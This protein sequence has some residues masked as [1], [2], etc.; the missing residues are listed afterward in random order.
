ML[1]RLSCLLVVAQLDVSQAFCMIDA[2]GAVIHEALLPQWAPATSCLAASLQPVLAGCTQS[3][4]ACAAKMSR[5]RTVLVLSSDEPTW[6][7]DLPASVGRYWLSNARNFSAVRAACAGKQNTVLVMEFG[8]GSAE[9]AV[10]ELAMAVCNPRVVILRQ[11]KLH[12][13]QAIMGKQRVPMV[14]NTC[15]LLFAASTLISAMAASQISGS[16]TSTK[17]A[18]EQI[19][20]AACKR[21][22]SL[23]LAHKLFSQLTLGHADSNTSVIFVFSHQPEPTA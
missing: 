20:E 17:A 1:W 2:D 14:T 5:A 15:R 13:L 11:L 8:V 12:K 7:H 9:L 18:A 6:F 16:S 22:K 4:P 10:D 19:L 23:I 21:S 3:P